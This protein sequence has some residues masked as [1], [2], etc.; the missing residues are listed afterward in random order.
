MTLVNPVSPVTPDAGRRRV[1]R[2]SFR[3]PVGILL[4][5]IYAVERCYQLGEGGMM[6]DCKD[7]K[8]KQGDLLA[9]SFFLP[10]GLVVM[11]RGI[12]RGVIAAKDTMPERYGIEFQNLGFQYKRAIRNFVAAATKD[13]GH[14]N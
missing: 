9:L 2:R 3:A 1:P 11:V 7:Q 13:D 6:M 14:S 5:G 12:V 4:K 8:L 10:T